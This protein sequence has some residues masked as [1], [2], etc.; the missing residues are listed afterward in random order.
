MKILFFFIFI[1]SSIGAKIIEIKHFSESIP[2]LTKDTIFILDID[3][4]LLVPKQMLG[5][6]MWFEDRIK[7]QKG[8]S[9]TEA[10]EKTLNEWEGIRHFTQMQIVEPGVQKIIEELQKKEHLIIGLSTQSL[11]LSKVTFKQLINNQIDLRVTAPKESYYFQNKNN[12]VLY[13]NGILFTSGTSKGKALF[14]LLEK[15]KQ[16]FKRI[17]FMNDKTSHLADIEQEA[18][19]NHVE[20]IGLRYGYSDFRKKSF[21]SRMAHIQ[22]NQSGF[23]RILSDE[24]AKALLV[25][26]ETH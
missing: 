1:Y 3:D 6:D 18:E 2:Y 17:V 5:S 7:Q 21:D 19:K 16:R 9:S 26:K 13:V 12:G 22:L 20:F 23:T 24:E 10:F 25:I 14:Q 11:T 4:T 15:T 8:L